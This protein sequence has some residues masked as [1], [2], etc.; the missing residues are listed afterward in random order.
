VERRKECLQGINERNVMDTVFSRLINL[1][2]FQVTLDVMF[3]YPKGIRSSRT[4]R[5]HPK[6]SGVIPPYI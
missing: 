4:T 1:P 3:D 5:V 2:R 6:Y